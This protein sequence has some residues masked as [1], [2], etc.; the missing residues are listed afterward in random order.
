MDVYPIGARVW[1]GGDELTVT[2]EPFALYGGEW[3]TATNDAGREL[4]I[5]TPRHSARLPNL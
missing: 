4:L 2:G 3:Q 5:P 1:R